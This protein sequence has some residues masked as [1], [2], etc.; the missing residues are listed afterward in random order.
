M[1]QH[2]RQILDQKSSSSVKTRNLTVNCPWQLFYIRVFRYHIKHRDDKYSYVRHT[3]NIIAEIIAFRFSLL[4]TLP[5][6]RST[7]SLLLFFYDDK[8]IPSI[9]HV[10]SHTNKRIR[11]KGDCLK[12]EKYYSQYL[13]LLLPIFFGS[14]SS[15]IAYLY[16][17]FHIQH[18]SNVSGQNTILFL[19][20]RKK[21]HEKNAK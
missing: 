18:V 9:E 15:F 11:E 4:S 1:L 10:P 6:L 2:K 16:V 12:R 20:K 17:T 21:K 13:S 3:S 19:L 8:K 7:V 14:L 5:L